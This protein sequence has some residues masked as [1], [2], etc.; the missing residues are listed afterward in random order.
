VLTSSLNAADVA[1]LHARILAHFERE[2]VE[3]E[4]FA[5]YVSAGIVGE[6]RATMRVLGEKHE[7]E[8]T[9]YTV[10]AREA[11]V[12]RIKAKFGV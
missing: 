7:E 3:A 6:I 2:M 1:A 10:R 4:I 11:D 12:A 5:P 9:R 8:G